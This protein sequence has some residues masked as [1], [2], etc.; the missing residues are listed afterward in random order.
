MTA[1]GLSLRSRRSTVYKACISTDAGTRLN[2]VAIPA[3][4]GDFQRIQVLPE[5]CAGLVLLV[6][7]LWDLMELATDVD[8]PRLDA[9]SPGFDGLH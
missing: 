2:A 8:D 4:V 3:L 1:T 9:G 7:K 6:K 5:H